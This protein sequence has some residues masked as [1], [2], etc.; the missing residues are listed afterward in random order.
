[1]ISVHDEI[2]YLVKEEDKNRAALA[3]QIS[4]LWTRSLFSY[5]LQMESLPQVRGFGGTRS[6]LHPL[7]APSSML[8]SCAFFSAV[9]LDHVLRKEVNMDCTTP[10][11][12]VPIPHGESIEIGE[13]LQRT[14]NGS[15]FADGRAMSEEAALPPLDIPTG[16]Q[17]FV[18]SKKQ[19]RAPLLSFL[20]AQNAQSG[21][22]LNEVIDKALK[23]ER[24]LPTL[25][26]GFD[27]S[28]GSG[29]QPVA[30]SPVRNVKRRTSSEASA[31]RK[32]YVKEAGAGAPVTGLRARRAPASY[33]N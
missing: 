12:P 11:Q 28:A 2:R 22:A 29:S 32:I 25:D 24:M 8:Q 14:H 10:S 13:T 9:D 16:A 1:M 21:R 23:S 30:I 17:L 27:W 15:L 3:L 20:D 19:Y 18:P 5:R 31:K 4:N 33:R 7:I 26:D 6:P